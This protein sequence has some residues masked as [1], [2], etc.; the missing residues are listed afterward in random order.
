MQ[1]LEHVF[2]CEGFVPPDRTRPRRL[3]CRVVG[4]TDVTIRADNNST[5]PAI[6]IYDCRAQRERSPSQEQDRDA[7]ERAVFA[8]SFKMAVTWRQQF[9]SELRI[10]HVTLASGLGLRGHYMAI[11]ADDGGGVGP[12]NEIALPVKLRLPLAGARYT[13]QPAMLAMTPVL[14]GDYRLEGFTVTQHGRVYECSVELTLEDNG[15]LRGTSR[16]LPALQS[17][18]LLGKWSSDELSWTLEYRVGQSTSARDAQ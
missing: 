4:E 10:C 1:Q 12:Q 7:S 3:L 6:F 13:R 17:C 8:C 5:D 18:P 16:E 2:E 14:P 9:R 15:V 11:G